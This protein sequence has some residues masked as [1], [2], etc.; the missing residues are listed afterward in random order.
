MTLLYTN[1]R[2]MCVSNIFCRKVALNVV[3][4]VSMIVS[5]IVSSHASAQKESSLLDDSKTKENFDSI[6]TDFQKNINTTSR[7]YALDGRT[8]TVSYIGNVVITQG[9]LKILAEEVI[10]DESEGKGNQVIFAV[11]TP[12]SYQQRLADGS[13]VKAKAN[14]IHYD[15]ATKVISLEGNARINQNSS[16]VSADTIIYYITEEKVV[17]NTSENSLTPVETIIGI[18]DFEDTKTDSNND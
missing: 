9:S 10:A 16:T 5:L 12:A 1:G 6:L 7:D 2:D 4:T 15:V 18:A 13:F 11:G 17:A 14:R 8:R 3:L